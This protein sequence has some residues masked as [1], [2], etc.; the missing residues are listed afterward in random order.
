MNVAAWLWRYTRAPRGRERVQWYTRRTPF[1]E[2][3]PVIAHPL[4]R[5]PDP[6][7]ELLVRALVF[8]AGPEATESWTDDEVESLLEMADLLDGVPSTG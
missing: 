4:Y 2:G 8:A 1:P 6:D 5:I 7:R 3:A